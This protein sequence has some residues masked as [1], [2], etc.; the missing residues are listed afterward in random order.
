MK[1]RARFLRAQRARRRSG[2]R[3]ASTLLV[4]GVGGHDRRG[5]GLRPRRPRGV[6]ATAGR[7]PRNEVDVRPARS[8]L[9]LPLVRHP[10]V[11]EPRLR[12]RGVPERRA[13][14]R[15]RADAGLEHSARAAASTTRGCSARAPGASA[16]RSGSPASTTACRSTRRRSSSSRARDVEIVTGPRIGIT[17][18]A[19]LSWRYAARGLAVS[20]PTD[21]P[22]TPSLMRSR[23]AAATPA[24]GNW[25]MHLPGAPL[26]AARRR[27]SASPLATP[28]RASRS[29]SPITLGTTP[30]IGFAN[31]ERHRGR[32][33]TARPL[34]GF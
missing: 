33:P 21:Q 32:T 17:K 30:C 12:R 1:L 8:R 34:R 7:T 9:R 3:S 31:D 23:G 26:C 20:Q 4:D 29:G 15:P 19:E 14:P 22:A 28:L 25:K 6:T 24:G 11:P 2:P 16:R 5:R 13:D 10:L 18:A 27:P